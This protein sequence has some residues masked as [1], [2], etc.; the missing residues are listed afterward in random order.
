MNPPQPTQLQHTLN[1]VNCPACDATR[2]ELSRTTEMK[3]LKFRDAAELVLDRERFYLLPE[4]A[5]LVLDESQKT[6]RVGERTY[7]DHCDFTRRLNTFFGEI[8][9]ANIHEGH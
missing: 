4:N 3:H 5:S 9:L 6:L 2:L 7:R 8:P 1:H